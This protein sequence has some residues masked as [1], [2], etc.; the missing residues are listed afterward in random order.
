MTLIFIKCW[1]KE[2]GW[3]NKQTKTE[4]KFTVKSEPS[5]PYVICIMFHIEWNTL[6]FFNRFT[7]CCVLAVKS[8]AISYLF[9]S[10]LKLRLKTPLC[11]DSSDHAIF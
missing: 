7:D 9:I 1:K 5:D 2:N 3:S 8:W 6:L 11:F 4:R 10:L